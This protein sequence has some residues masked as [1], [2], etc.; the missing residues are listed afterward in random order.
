MLGNDDLA[1]DLLLNRADEALY[2]SK[3]KGRDQFSTWEENQIR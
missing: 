2:A 3:G 1:L